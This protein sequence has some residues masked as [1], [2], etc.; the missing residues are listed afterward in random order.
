MHFGNIRISVLIVVIGS[1]S[2]TFSHATGID[3]LSLSYTAT[4]DLGNPVV[5]SDQ[6]QSSSVPVNA[7]C[8][9]GF[10]VSQ[11]ITNGSTGPFSG[12]LSSSASVNGEIGVATANSVM[13]FDT[14][15]PLD[16]S[17]STSGS[18][19]PGTTFS[20]IKLTD[21]TDNLVLFQFSGR[22]D[23]G[24]QD[25]TGSFTFSLDASKDYRLQV[26]SST[27]PDN[28]RARV[29]YS[30]PEPSSFALLLPCFATL[31][32]ACRKVTAK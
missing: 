3:V 29:D 17:L 20:T 11:A 6:E 14:S 31:C 4:A 13:D 18:G 22:N 32:I 28:T 12:F 9:Q 8:T 27:G 19:I 30:V 16:L 5:C 7:S 24:F 15:A 2:L 25:L 23:F 1:G 21:L 10:A 26:S